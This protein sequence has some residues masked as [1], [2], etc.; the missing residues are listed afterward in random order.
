MTPAEFQEWIDRL[1]KHQIDKKTKK[2][3]IQRS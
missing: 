3:I 1:V 2:E